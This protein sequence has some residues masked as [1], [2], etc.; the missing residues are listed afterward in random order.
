MIN[1]FILKPVNAFLRPTNEP[2][3]ISHCYRTERGIE[4]CFTGADGKYTHAELNQ[5]E[6]YDELESAR[7]SVLF[8]QEFVFKLKQRKV[9]C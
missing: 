4:V 1:P 9:K 3:E 7:L 8:D 2:I 6:I 5:I